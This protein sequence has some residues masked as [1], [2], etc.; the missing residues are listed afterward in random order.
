MLHD[1]PLEYVPS[2][3]ELSRGIWPRYH[4]DPYWADIHELSLRVADAFETEGRGD[5]GAI[6]YRADEAYFRALL[7]L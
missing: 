1:R 2:E 5:T 7:K 6:T 4:E 3:L